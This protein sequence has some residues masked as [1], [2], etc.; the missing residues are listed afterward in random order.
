MVHVVYILFMFASYHKTTV[1]GR[2]TYLH[3]KDNVDFSF[4]FDKFLSSTMRD[5][6][7]SG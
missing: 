3:H 6:T 7:Y 2:I 4:L 1:M 5:G